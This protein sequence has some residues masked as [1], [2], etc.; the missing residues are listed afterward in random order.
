VLAGRGGALFHALAEKGVACR[1]L[2]KLIH[3]IRPWRDWAAYREIKSVLKELKPDLVT[4]HSNKAGLLGRL[5]AHSLQIPVIHTSHGFLFSGRGNSA[6]GRFYRLMEKIA[7]RAAD[8]VIAVSESEM[9]AA[10]SLGVIPTEKMAMVYNGLPDCGP[11]F[12]ARPD[13]HPP[14]VM[15]VARFAEP[16]DHLTL[17]KALGGLKGLD[18]S[19]QLIGD[20]AGKKKAEETAEEQG[21]TDRVTF[22][23]QRED[24]CALLAKSQFFVLSSKREGFPISILEAM[25]AGLPVVSS[26][27]GGAGEA[28]VEGETGFLFQAGNALQLQMRLEEL[29]TKP[30]LRRK[31]GN[32]GR[33]RFKKYFTLDRMA[34]KTM[35]VYRD[36][37]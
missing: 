31:L 32:A 2:E 1:K 12:L 28:V 37:L 4:T 5:A 29:I 7:A 14:V 18:W 15:M 19:L 9:I 35:E 21:I 16:K 36:I 30:I 11:Q 22:S 13:R 17:L 23:G 24:V 25:R 6:A 34:D 20:G 33:E 26:N 8:R 27:V 10:E 3:P